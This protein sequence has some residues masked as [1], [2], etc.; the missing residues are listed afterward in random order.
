MARGSGGGG[1]LSPLGGVVDALCDL[2]LL[3]QDD[4]QLLARSV[5]LAHLLARDAAT[6]RHV[7]ASR[8][9]VR[10]RKDGLGLLHL[11]QL[12]QAEALGFPTEC[13][14]CREWRRRPLEE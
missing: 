6:E 10:G 1:A 9:R 12:G 13:F 14:H 3:G 4:A 7:G 2:G 11:G 5:Q 8:P